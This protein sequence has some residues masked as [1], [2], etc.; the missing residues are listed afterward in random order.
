MKKQKLI[1][2]ASC[3][4]FVALISA[5]SSSNSESNPSND[6]I[7][8]NFVN[9]IESLNSV[10]DPIKSFIASA[11]IASSKTSALNKENAGSVFE[12]LS[13]YKSFVVVVEDHTVVL[14]TNVQDCKQSGSW[15]ACMPK[16]N[17]YIKKGELVYQEDYIN[18]I[19]GRPDSQKR[20]VYFFE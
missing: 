9:N 15:G 6:S 5:C 1:L 7:A 14:V 11:N 13:N 4:I 16:G 3:L 10:K 18:N 12:E 17:G 19:I 2:I 8:L 20:T